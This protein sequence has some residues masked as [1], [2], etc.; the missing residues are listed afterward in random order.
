MLVLGERE[1]ATFQKDE[2]TR[3]PEQN[4]TE[5]NRTVLQ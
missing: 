2:M 4:T 5:Q 1:Q 3:Q